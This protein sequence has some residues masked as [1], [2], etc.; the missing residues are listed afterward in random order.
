MAVTTL[1]HTAQKMKG[2]QKDLPVSAAE[3][4]PYLNAPSQDL[5]AFDAR[6]SASRAS[7]TNSAVM[8]GFIEQPTT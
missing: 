4:T 5:L 8:R 3:L 2:L 7:S 1:A 6:L